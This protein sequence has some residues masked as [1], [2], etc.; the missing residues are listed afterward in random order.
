MSF[1]KNFMWGGAI[2][3]NQAEGEWLE[4]GKNPIFQML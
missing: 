1:P 3:A 2:A 4:D